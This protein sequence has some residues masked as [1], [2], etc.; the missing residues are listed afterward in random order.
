MSTIS[1]FEYEFHLTT[2]R[3][4]SQMMTSNRIGVLETFRSVRRNFSTTGL[5]GGIFQNI[6][7]V[8]YFVRGGFVG[9]RSRVSSKHLSSHLP[10]DGVRFLGG[11]KGVALQLQDARVGVGSPKDFDRCWEWLRY[12]LLLNQA[13]ICSK[14]HRV[15]GLMHI[16]HV[17]VQSFHVGVM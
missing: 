8:H 11:Q 2:S 13:C 14:P 12:S 6:V 4:G 9:H 3:N 7:R 17:K 1:S 5:P 10:V 16:K 15:E